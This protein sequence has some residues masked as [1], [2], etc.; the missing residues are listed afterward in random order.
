M[1]ITGMAVYLITVP[2]LQIGKQLANAL[3]EKNA[4]ACVNILPSVTSMYR[5]KGSVQED[6][7]LLLICKSQQQHMSLISDI[8]RANHPYELPEVIQL[9]VSYSTIY[10]HPC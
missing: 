3:L 7:E 6:Q 8:V 1:N 10:G 9:P 2:S 4:V 5:W